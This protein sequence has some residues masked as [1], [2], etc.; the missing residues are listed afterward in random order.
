MSFD[1]IPSRDTAVDMCMR[2]VGD[3]ILSGELCPGDHL[4]PERELAQ[5]F[6]VN[7]TTL[8]TALRGLSAKGLLRVRQGSG[9]QV[10]D[11]RTSGGSELL[12]DLCRQISEQKEAV[13]YAVDLLRVR[14]HLATSVL[15]TLL[16]KET[17]IDQGPIRTAV[18]HFSAIVMSGGTKEELAQADL[19]VLS[20]IVQ[21]SE[22]VVLSLSIHPV[23]R[24]LSSFHAL[25]DAIYINP[26]ESVLAYQGLLGWL[27][28][29]TEQGLS[30]IVTE[31]EK[32][33]ALTVKR[34]GLVFEA[35]EGGS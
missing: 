30:L 1:A 4:P 9:C 22:S 13:K 5:Q 31:M 19:A 2:A 33:D 10:E 27:M 34:V 14:R 16:L 29:P 17:P 12:V 35:A 18:A 6:G 32:K 26:T 21:S 28:A 11:F 8:R 7:R 23:A 15:E 20:A 25:R 3:A 24:V